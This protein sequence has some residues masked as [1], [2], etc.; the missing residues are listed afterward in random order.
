MGKVTI[1]DSI[2][3]SGKSTFCFNKMNEEKDKRFIYITPY[4]S[5]IDRALDFCSDRFFVQPKNVGSGKLESFNN[6]LKEGRNIASTHALFKFCNNDTL[7]YLKEMNYTLV[8]DEVMSVVETIKLKKSDIESII[9]NYVEVDP[10]T[11]RL[12]W[13]D[14]TYS[15]RFDD[16]R[17]QVE[18]GNMYFIRDKLLIWVFPIDIFEAL[19]ETFVCTYLFDGQLQRYHY[20]ANNVK[21]E[22]KSINKINDTYELSEYNEVEDLSH[23]KK[24]INIYEGRLNTIGEDVKGKKG[25]NLTVAWYDRQHKNKLDGLDV[26]KKNLVNYFQN[27]C[28]TSSDENMWTVFKDHKNKCKGS[29]YTKGFVSCGCRATNEYSHKKTL[30]YCI[31]VFNNPMIIGFFQ[32]NG[33]TVNQEKY[34]L[35][36]LVQWIFR[37]SLRNGEKINIYIPSERMRTLLK[38][39]L[40]G[41]EIN[42][43][44]LDDI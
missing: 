26:L 17:T 28:G 23:I 22:Y 19:S 12:T 18:S 37:S 7:K 42:H 43:K 4:L 2:P 44:S 6:L 21:Y 16:I 25:H 9:K 27:I 15:G 35:A 39:W 31:N 36:E 5:E 33:V 20:D 13:I 30:A 3:G 29:K 10:V 40:D 1:I 32:D 41:K 14:I 11:K 8:L 38:C 34:A 24:L